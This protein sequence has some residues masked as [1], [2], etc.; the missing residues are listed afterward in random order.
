MALAASAIA[1]ALYWS[2]LKLPIIYDSLLH[3]R[4]ATDLNLATVWLPT[5]TYAFYRPLI[6]FPMLLI[7]GMFGHY[8]A[9][10]LHGLNVAL[11][12]VNVALVV[13]LSWRLWHKWAWALAAGLLLALF[14]FAYQAVA[15]HGHNV[16]LTTTGLILVGLHAY[17]YGVRERR[18]RWWLLTCLFFLLALLSHETAV[19]FGPLAALIHWNYQGRFPFPALRYGRNTPRASRSSTL[20]FPWLVFALLGGLYAAVYRFLPISRAVQ[21]PGTGGGLWPKALF[22][23]QAAAHPVTWFA[24]VLPDLSAVVI[25]LGGMAIALGLTAWSACGPSNRLPLL[26]GWGWWG[27]VSLLLAFSLPTGYLLHGPRLLYLVGAGL[28]LLWPTLLDP[29][30]R[31]T[32][33]GWLLWTAALG[34]ILL[35]GWGFVRGQLDRYTQLAAPVALMEEVM[36]DRPPAEGLLLVNLPE[37]PSPPRNT[38]PICAEHVA[39]LG[40]HLFAEELVVENLRVNRPVRAIKLPERLGEPRYPYAVSGETDLSQP[41]PADWAAAGSQVFVVA[42]TDDGVHAQHVGYLSPSAEGRPVAQYGPYQL[43][44]GEAAWAT[45]PNLCSAC[46]T[47]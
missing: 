11:H 27:L 10:L 23:M 7:R 19:L 16:H 26:L 40:Q 28:G 2:S 30:S 14:P 12:A 38:Y 29:L 39:M 33:V 15:V 35:T 42:Y 25:V 44:R 4:I 8:P 32:R 6:F 34:F 43:L 22:L 36:A 1:I 24:H 17:L 46:T 3:I 20:A 9:W 31:I 13:A 37:W 21:T 47:M 41:I 45:L 5:E 18:L